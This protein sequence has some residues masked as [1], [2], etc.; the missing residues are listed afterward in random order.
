MRAYASKS[1]ENSSS[2]TT[3]SSEGSPETE[4][5]LPSTSRNCN[6]SQDFSAKVLPLTSSKERLQVFSCFYFH[7]FS[8]NLWHNIFL[9]R[10]QFNLQ[11]AV[12]RTKIFM[13]KINLKKVFAPSTIGAVCTMF[14][15]FCGV[16]SKFTIRICTFYHFKSL[17]N[18]FVE[19][20][21]DIYIWAK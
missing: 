12:Q 11:K 8:G 10:S 6:N 5:L 19:L 2:I 7:I 14:I 21:H 13:G 1:I 3:S 20:N 4:P 17:Q 9:T 16:N 18:D 15:I